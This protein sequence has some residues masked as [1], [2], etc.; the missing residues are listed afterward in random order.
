MFRTY[1]NIL[2]KKVYYIGQNS[3]LI[4]EKK[5]VSLHL[6]FKMKQIMKFAWG[7]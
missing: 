6:F 7:G 4:L 2:V 3:V 5:L 1:K